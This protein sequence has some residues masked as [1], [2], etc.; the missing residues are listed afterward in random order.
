MSKG[1]LDD[2]AIDY[3]LSLRLENMNNEENQIFESTTLYMTPTWEMIRKVTLQYFKPFNG[4]SDII[5]LIHDSSSR[6]MKNHCIK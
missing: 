5:K 4:P 3:I 2:D 1:Y 6:N